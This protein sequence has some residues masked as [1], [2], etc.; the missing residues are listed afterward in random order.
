MKTSECK[1]TFKYK[2]YSSRCMA[3]PFDDN[4]QLLRHISVSH[5]KELKT[6]TKCFYCED[7]LP[8]SN[9]NEHVQTMHP[10]KCLLCTA[11]FGEAS[12][13]TNHMDSAHRQNCGYCNAFFWNLVELIEHVRVHIN[14]EPTGAGDDD[15]EEEVQK[16][17][18][19]KAEKKAKKKAKKEAEKGAKKEAEK[20][21]ENIEQLAEEK[22]LPIDKD[23]VSESISQT[24]KNT[25]EDV[26]N[27]SEKVQFITKTQGIF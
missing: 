22:G 6:L 21:V 3:E 23:D 5:P 20:D 24:E 26:G 27:C 25:D 14:V 2:C 10:Y 19:K 11:H 8:H 15:S 12:A 7:I 16:E 9:M 18:Q 17:V 1:S 4:V 13:W